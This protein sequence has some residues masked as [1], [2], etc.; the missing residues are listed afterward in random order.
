MRGP[1]LWLSRPRNSKN[2]KG[3]ETKTSTSGISNLTSPLNGHFKSV[4][5][6]RNSSVFK[7]IIFFLKTEEPGKHILSQEVKS[8]LTVM[9]R[10]YRTCSCLDEKGTS[11][12]C[13]PF[14]L[15][16]DKKNIKQIPLESHSTRN[17][18]SL[19]QNYPGHQR[20]ERSEKLSWPRGVWGDIMTEDHVVPCV[21]SWNRKAHEEKTETRLISYGH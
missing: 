4:N 18:I 13:S 9:N 21:R 1:Q 5:S 6:Q 20:Y 3:S 17:L 2:S 16:N 8:T 14:Y 19:P 11:P 15:S 7:I 10:I 12:L